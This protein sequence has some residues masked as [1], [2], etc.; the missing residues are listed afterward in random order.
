MKI[1]EIIRQKRVEKGMTQEQVALALGVSTPAVNKWE[2][3]ICYPDITL[4]PPLARILGTDLNTLL[5]FQ[6]ELS[7]EEVGTFLDDVYIVSKS[8]GTDAAFRM[9]QD[10]F[11]GCERLVLQHLSQKV[12]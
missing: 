4:L 9:V 11:S 8:E 5:S 7:K 6:E 12:R 2:K 1:H 10:P 3:A